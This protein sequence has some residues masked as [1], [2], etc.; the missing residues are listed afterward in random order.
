MQLE[1][2]RITEEIQGQEVMIMEQEVVT[3]EQ[4]EVLFLQEEQQM[5]VDGVII[6]RP[7]VHQDILADHQQDLVQEDLESNLEF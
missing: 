1:E 3:K 6:E 7:E 4:Q 5:Q 2:H